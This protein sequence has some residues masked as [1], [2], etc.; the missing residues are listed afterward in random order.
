MYKKQ[1]I[2]ELTNL[3]LDNYHL[4]LNESLFHN[5]NGYIGIRS[6]FEEGYPEDYQSIRGQ[7]ING[8]YDYS[9][10][11]QA[12]RLYGLIQEKQTML[13]VADTQTIKI[14]LDGEEFNM[15]DGT[16][17]KS[18]RWVDMNKGIT[19]RH[20]LWRSSQGKEVE[21]TIKRMASF[22]Q[23]P[24]FT[25][26]YE[27]IPINFSGDFM[28]ES[29]HNGNA[30]NYVNPDDPRVADE[31]IKYLNPISCEIKKGASYIT[32]ATSKSNC[33]ICSCVKNVLFQEHDRQFII[34]DHHAICH[35][36]T[37]AKQ[38]EKIKLIK[39]AVFCDSIRYE[40][41][42]EQID[43]ELKNALS[44]SLDEIYKKQEEYLKHYWNNCSVEIQGDDT[45]DM[46]IRYNLYQLIQSVTKDQYGNIAPK[47]LSGEG[48]E[49]HFFWD[50]EMYIQPFFTITNPSISKS[51]IEYR[52]SIL[53]MAKENAKILGHEKGALYPWRTIMGKECSGY[54]PSGSAQY[55]INGDIAYSII[56][57]YLA[58]KDISL[59]VE[60]G[61]EIIYETARLWM[62]TGN[63]YKGNFYI[64]DVTG[65]DEYTCIVNNNYYTNVLAQYH[66][67]W[68]VK[69]YT[70][71]QS[72]DY[73][74]T[75]VEKIQ[76]KEDEI[77]EFK[78]AAENMYLPYD[79]TLKINPQ[80]D[81]FLQKRKWDLNSIP[82]EKFPLLLHY[83]PLHLYRHQICK[84]PDTILAHFIIEDAQSKETMINSYNYYEK[85]TTHDSSLS[86]CVFSIMASKLGMEEK[87]FQYFGCSANL[88]LVDKQNNTKD[89]IHTSNMAGNYMAIVYGFGGFRL[90]ESGICFAPILP[91]TWNSY[92]FK[93]CYEDSRI[94]VIV[95]ENYCYF[96]LEH[97][98]IK[99]I[100]V[101]D[102][103]YLLKDII[104]VNRSKH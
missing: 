10:M 85:I 65:P 33:F 4:L 58:T 84:Q 94:I 57:Y 95:K 99:N 19:G 66:L 2:Y 81:S 64:N 44:I 5:A 89:G 32:S 39:Y 49:G 11:K 36:S 54:F 73:F 56:A 61:A 50:T 96:R 6:V 30:L 23:L 88:D 52:Y 97:G 55:H 60:K 8:F 67:K 31:G 17:L 20:V 103:S 87:A 98:D 35:L 41:Y 24:L 1:A 69:F 9:I 79:E 71:L 7:Y 38:G 75:L 63:F 102:K 72:R 14:F 12:E 91:E 42:R 16:V 43:L 101:Y 46:A 40:N 77:A 29:S 13:N 34:D 48:Y 100:F 51:L 92:Q 104:I 70:L 78:E 93:I 28:I 82:Q 90:K 3:K 15:F 62:D 26:E 68:A 37:E 59:I 53:E 83:H 25:I 18:K 27:V 80:D 22:Y 86:D 45:L 74:T 76:L 21:I 47:G